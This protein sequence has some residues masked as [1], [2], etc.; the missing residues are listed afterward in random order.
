M[1]LDFFTFQTLDSDDLVPL[2]A[3][4][5]DLIRALS[6]LCIQAYQQL[7]SITEKRLQN[8]IGATTVKTMLV[9][10]MLSPPL[11]LLSYLLLPLSPSPCSVGERD[12]P[13]SVCL[14]GKV[15]NVQKA[16]QLRPQGCWR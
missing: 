16:S 10:L 7:L 3:D 6:D 5:S 14:C 11:L 15:G 12:H 8:I 4:V 1:L 13:R 9:L 2:A